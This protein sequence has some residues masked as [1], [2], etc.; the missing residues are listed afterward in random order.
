MSSPFNSS[1]SSSSDEEDD[2]VDMMMFIYLSKYSSTFID[3]LP[4]RSS[5]LSGKEYIREIVCEVRCYESFRMKQQVFL[6][7]SDQ[8]KMLGLL[9]DSR[10]VTVEEGLTKN[11]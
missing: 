6:N 10:Y 5:M 11:D 4:C 8:L 7:L 1:S 9:Q 3:R 2:D